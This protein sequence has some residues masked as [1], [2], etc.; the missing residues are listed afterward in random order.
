MTATV[1]VKNENWKQREAEKERKEK[2]ERFESMFQTQY[3]RR[4]STNDLETIRQVHEHY[5]SNAESTLYLYKRC[6]E[7]DER[8]EE[9][10]RKELGE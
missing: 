6:K 1:E 4:P 9:M 5:Q 7:W 2:A 10:K 8:Y 3:G